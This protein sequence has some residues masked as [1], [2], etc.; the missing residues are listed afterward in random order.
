MTYA[1][2][3]FACVALAAQVRAVG[4]VQSRSGVG[5]SG[6]QLDFYFGGQG[7][8]VHRVYTD[9]G[10]TFFVDNPRNGNYSV[11]VLQGSRSVSF[12]VSVNGSN[13]SPRVLQVPW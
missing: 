5:L 7:Q 2:V 11:T 3:L 12:N 6:C 9:Q 1:V 8:V 4:Q 10:G 13:L